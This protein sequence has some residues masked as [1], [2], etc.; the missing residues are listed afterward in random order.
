[1]A[2]LWDNA[3]LWWQSP[4]KDERPGTWEAMSEQMIKFFAPISATIIA[5]ERL[6]SLRQLKSVRAYTNDFK[7]LVLNIP[8]MAES[9][10]ID[11]YKRGLKQ[12]VRLQ[13]VFVKPVGFEQ[14]CQVAE[15]I[16]GI[17]YNY[18]PGPKTAKPTLDPFAASGSGTTPMDIG[19]MQEQQKTYAEAAKTAP[20]FPK[21]TPEE[22][23]R[24]MKENGCFYCRKTGHRAAQCP[25]KKGKAPVKNNPY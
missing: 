15:E 24:L 25:V 13:V 19:A 11:R 9:K 6:A 4:T 16:D 1:V 22:K 10:T 7:R 23:S 8:D 17:L 20:K 14:T 2:L 3:P 21:L 12:E 18:R 5:R